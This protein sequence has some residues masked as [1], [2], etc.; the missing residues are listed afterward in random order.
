MT[1]TPESVDVL[2]DLLGITPGT[3]LHRVR[4]ARDKV[5][6]ATQ[7]S[8]AQ[9][10]DPQLTDNLAL[11]ERLWVAYFASHLTPNPL[12]AEYYL[13]QLQGLDVDPA[14]VAAV[15]AGQLEALGDH[16]LQ[17]ILVFTRTLIERPVEGDRQALVVLQQAGLST[18]EIVLLSQL[19]AFLSYQVRL[20][21]GLAALLSAGVAS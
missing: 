3:E 8:H 20:A 18:A 6:A 15:N 19:I 2:D 5:L 13:E 14:W 21:A 1:I 16:R 9:F 10:F 4:H 11:S 7:S 12:L 17:A